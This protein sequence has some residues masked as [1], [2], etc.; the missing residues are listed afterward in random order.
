M[1]NVLSALSSFDATMLTLH[2]KAAAGMSRRLRFVFVWGWLTATAAI[3]AEDHGNTLDVR[4]SQTIDLV[5]MT[6]VDYYLATPGSITTF[7]NV[8]PG[9]LYVF[10]FGN[11]NTTIRRDHAFLENGL[12]FHPKAGTSVFVGETTTTI[13]QVTPLFPSDR[14]PRGSTIVNLMIAAARWVFDLSSRISSP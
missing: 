9:R 8:V 3:A 7:L 10:Y 5:G 1:F 4:A 6:R 2:P 14:T 11:G 12:D 13:R